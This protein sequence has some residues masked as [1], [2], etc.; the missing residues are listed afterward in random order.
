MGPLYLSGFLCGMY[1]FKVKC[2][3]CFFFLLQRSHGNKD[4]KI[5]V[6]RKQ[7]MLILNALLQ[8]WTGKPA[9][10]VNLS[11]SFNDIFCNKNFR[12]I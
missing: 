9:T 3:I 1:Y 8:K 10:P 5:A 12:S 4:I 6:V 7:L 2:N 11:L